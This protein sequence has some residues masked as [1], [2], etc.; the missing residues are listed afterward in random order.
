M[1]IKQDRGPRPFHTR[2]SAVGVECRCRCRDKRQRDR[3]QRQLHEQLWLWTSMVMDM[4][5]G[6]RHLFAAMIHD[7]YN[8][9]LISTTTKENEKEPNKA[10]ATHL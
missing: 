4:N 2:Q 8:L 5:K 6:Q 1:T 9:I 10:I 3:D 7:S